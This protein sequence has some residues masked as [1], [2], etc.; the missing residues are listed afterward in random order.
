MYSEFDLG[1][2]PGE[3][4]TQTCSDRLVTVGKS[5]RISEARDSSQHLFTEKPV[6]PAL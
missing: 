1:A 6:L 2:S 3:S 4:E 5:E